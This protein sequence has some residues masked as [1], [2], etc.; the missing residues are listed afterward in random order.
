MW[1]LFKPMEK[2][3]AKGISIAN[4]GG[5][6]VLY[7]NLAEGGYVPSLET[8][9]STMGGVIDV[10]LENPGVGRIVFMHRRNYIYNEE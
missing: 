1:I 8:S 5:T 10:L 2:K 3:E 7:F 6:N 4:E 9:G